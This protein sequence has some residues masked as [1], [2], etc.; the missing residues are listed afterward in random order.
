MKR[1]VEIC[2]SWFL[3]NAEVS[4]L[5]LVYFFLSNGF[6][7]IE[8]QKMAYRRCRCYYHQLSEVVDLYHL[9]T[10]VE[11]VFQILLFLHENL[12]VL[13]DCHLYQVSTM[14]F[15]LNKNQESQTK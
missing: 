13:H 14:A 12:V 15:Y 4:K 5:N 11:D 2:L 7:P 8:S 9:H 6:C 10:V 3:Q 1:G